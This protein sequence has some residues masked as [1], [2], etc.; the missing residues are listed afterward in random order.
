RRTDRARRQV[1]RELA[2]L[3]ERA[4]QLWATLRERWARLAMALSTDY[5]MRSGLALPSA[6]AIAKLLEADNALRVGS[7][8]AALFADQP[9]RDPRFFVANREMLRA[10][11]RAERNWQQQR[12]ANSTLIIGGPGSGKTSL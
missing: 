3:R 11:S 6:T 2:R 4:E 7:E 10:I 1:W 12:S 8:Y 9:I 5:R